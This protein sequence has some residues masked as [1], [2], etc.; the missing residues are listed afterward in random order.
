MYTMLA[1][2]SIALLLLTWINLYSIGPL[3]CI[4]GEGPVHKRG[5]V[6]GDG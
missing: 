1:A 5:G 3:T 2:S 4:S 6:G